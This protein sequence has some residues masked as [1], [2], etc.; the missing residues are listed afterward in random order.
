MPTITKQ[1]IHSFLQK[2]ESVNANSLSLTGYPLQYLH[3][4]LKQ[5][6]YFVRMYADVLEKALTNADRP[7]HRIVFMDY[8]AGNGLLGL[9]AK[10]C[11]CRKVYINDISPFFLEAA[12]TLAN[13]LQIKPDGW[14]E[15]DWK[16]CEKYFTENESPDMV[17]GTDVIE[18]IYNLD[19]LFAGMKKI[20]PNMVS[21]FT[22]ASNTSNP[23]KNRSLKKLQ[24]RDENIE[25]NADHAVPGDDYA[26]LPFV[27]TRRRMITKK[28]PQLKDEIIIQL[29]KATRGL[30]REDIF[31]AVEKYNSTGEFPKEPHHQSNTC[32]PVTGSWTERL[33]TIEEYKMIYTKAGFSLLVYNGFYNSWQQGIKRIPLS[34]ANAIIK[35]L[36][37]KGKV[38]A[39]YITLVGK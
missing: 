28:F 6:A 33:L 23:L 8:G 29:A 2:L 1:H 21:V 22:T 7:L 37:A 11:G 5:K 36:G 16:A 26:G 13:H 35:L 10:Y 18:H 34:F 24:W 31:P 3:L 12:K 20:N 17:A 27:E 19:E 25:S 9:F 4:L 32:D 39:P 15:G 30:H 14:I 38:I